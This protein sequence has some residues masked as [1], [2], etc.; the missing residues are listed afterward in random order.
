MIP[1]EN[2][3]WLRFVHADQHHGSGDRVLLLQPRANRSNFG[4]KRIACRVPPSFKTFHYVCDEKISTGADRQ[5]GAREVLN[6]VETGP[7]LLSS[8]PQGC[9]LPISPSVSVE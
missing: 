6:L 4:E 2:G 5:L 9:A 8:V 3:E 7:R 1:V